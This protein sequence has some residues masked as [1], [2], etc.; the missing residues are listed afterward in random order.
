[1]SK[2]QTPT[3]KL[4]S[5]AMHCSDPELTQAVETLLTIRNERFP[6]TKAPKKAS[7]PKKAVVYPMGQEAES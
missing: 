2:R 6:R 4:I 7:R 5:Y 3:Q 1:M